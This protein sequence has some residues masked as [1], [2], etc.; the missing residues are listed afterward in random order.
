[1][2][3]TWIKLGLTSLFWALMFFLGQYAV[4][5]MTPESV[6]G[7]RFLVAGGI[8]LPLVWWREGVDWAG[9][10]RHAAPLLAMAIVGI[11]GFN[12]SLFHG[13]RHTSPLNAALIMALCPA[14]ITALSA[15]LLRER[16]S[17]RQLAG[18]ILGLA[19]VAIVISKGSLTALLT[20]SLQRGDLY[21]LL[22][23]ICWAIYS[24]LPRRFITGLAPQQITVA[25]LCAGGVLISAFAHATQPDFLV[26]PAASVGAAILGM[27][28]FGSVLAYLWWNDGVR[29]VG[30]GRAA[31]FMNMVPL[32][33]LLIGL[34]LGQPVAPTQLVGAVLVIGGL[35]YATPL[36]ATT[37]RAYLL[38]T[39]PNAGASK[40]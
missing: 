2:T 32:F 12:L 38:P 36:A 7:W 33:T 6:G 10:R 26:L 9:L 4:A 25:T 35:C 20:L 28:V 17:G 23:A 19:G 31:L 14:L 13:L 15:T 39:A 3:A 22:A 11:G 24:T 27:A 8:L 30:A 16:I 1:M 21:V 18:L 40:P 5:F 29:K 37:A 34:A